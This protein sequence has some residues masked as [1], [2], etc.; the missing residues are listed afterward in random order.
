MSNQIPKSIIAVVGEIIGSHLYNHTKIE[1]LFLESGAPEDIPTGSCV[2]KAKSWLVNCNLDKNVDAF[3]VLG[4]V[5]EEYMDSDTDEND[6]YYK[7]KSTNRERI[8]SQLKKHNLQYTSG[9]KI[10]NNDVFNFTKT[11]EQLIENNDY[12]Q[13]REHYNRALE[14]IENDPPASL[15]AS[16][17]ILESLFKT[18][19]TTEKLDMPKNQKVM[20]MW[21]EVKSHLNLNPE[22]YSEDSIKKILSGLNSIIDGLSSLRNHA[23]SAHGHVKKSYKIEDRHSRLAVL[24]SC[25]LSVFVIEVWEN[26]KN[27]LP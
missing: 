18:I 5:I 25:A 20:L 23:G 15:T 22:G 12:S 27:K 7:E 16:C 17:A 26:K 1:T 10:L 24:S 13:I 3:S 2:D 19:I 21:K 14:N 11:F 8:L 9:G 6:Y 4:K